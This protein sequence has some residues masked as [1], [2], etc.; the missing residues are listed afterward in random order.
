VQYAQYLELL[1]YSSVNNRYGYAMNWF[2]EM[3]LTPG[4]PDHEGFSMEQFVL[5]SAPE[6]FEYSE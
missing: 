2:E 6:G 4:L 3:M 1:G 5:P